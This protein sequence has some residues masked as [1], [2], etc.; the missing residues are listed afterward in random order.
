MDLAQAQ[1]ILKDYEQSGSVKKVGGVGTKHLIPW[2]LISK[3]EGGETKWR[4]ISD[5][6][7]INSQFQVK[8][9]KLDHLQHIFPILQKG[10]WAAKID[11]K[12]AHFHIPVS[13]ALRPYLRHQVGT[14]CGNSKQAV[15]A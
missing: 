2:F 9:F 8:P 13:Q 12:D 6:R 5:C 14:L 15:L 4:F 7:E 10:H 11:L 1:K 3:P